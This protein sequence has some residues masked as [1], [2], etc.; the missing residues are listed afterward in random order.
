MSNTI[1]K[2]YN[3][4]LRL[5]RWQS[6]AIL[7]MLFLA[8]SCG[9]GKHLPPAENNH[10]LE[11]RD[12]VRIVDS[13]RITEKARYKDYTSLLDTLSIEDPHANMKAWVD[14]T[15]NILAGEL[16]VEPVEEKTRIEYKDR[17]VHDTTYI[18]EPFPVEVEKVVA[19]KIFP[20]SLAL[21]FLF[22]ALTGLWIYLKI[23]KRKIGII[24]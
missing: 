10:H 17:E 20:W 15:H 14:T 23:Q 8:V 6:G 18:K 5:R 9:L 11:V 1:K 4:L 2:S 22:L 19:P 24:T 21:N 13:V 7:V 3:S 12:S 16:N